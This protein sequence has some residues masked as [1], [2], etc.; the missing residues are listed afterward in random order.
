MHGR[1]SDVRM[2]GLVSGAV[3]AGLS[4]SYCEM[5]SVQECVGICDSK[6]SL[7]TSSGLSVRHNSQNSKA[8]SALTRTVL[9]IVLIGI[10][11]DFIATD[12][13]IRITWT[14]CDF[15]T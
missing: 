3:I 1:L 9:N 2:Y 8:H 11:S 10:C 6:C 7:L 13:H 4:R 15:I 14:Y 12:S 5:R